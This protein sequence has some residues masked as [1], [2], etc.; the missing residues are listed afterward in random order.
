LKQKDDLLRKP[1]VI[2]SL[3]H[4]VTIQ[5]IFMKDIMDL[6]GRALMSVIFFFEAYDK[7][8][9]MTATRHSMSEIGIMWNQ[10]WLIYGTGFCLILG[11]SLILFGYRVGLGVFLILLYWIPLTFML[12][13]F[14]D[15]PYAHEARRGVALHFMKNIAIVGGLFTLYVN[16]SG[17]YSIKRLLA[18][19]RVR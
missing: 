12:N 17:R 7:I 9:F 2:N 13:Q 10:N 14:W 15:Y 18:T 3:F 8:F 6:F 4:S 16:G 5:F 1:L 19:T 11:A